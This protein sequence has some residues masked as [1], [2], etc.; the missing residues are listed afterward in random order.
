VTRFVL[1][2][3]VPARFGVRSIEAAALPV[4][5]LGRAG[6]WLRVLLALALLAAGGWLVWR[7][8]NA[9]DDKLDSLSPVP[10]ADQALDQRLR[11]D[12]G[13]PDVGELVVVSGGNA[14]AALEGAERV[15]AVL[16]RLQASGALA[17]FDSPARYLPSA[18]AQ[19]LRREALPDARNLQRNLTEATRTVPFR[20]DAFAPFIEQVEIARQ[21]PTLKREDLRG[22]G[23]ALKVDTLLVQRHG[24][25]FAMLPLRGVSQRDAIA[26]ALAAS[27][28][29]A[30]LLDLK[31][32]SDALYG[33]Y[34]SRALNFSLI[35]AAA[36]AI[37]LLV[38]LRSLR[39][40]L[41]VIVPLAAAIVATCAIL[42]A[43]GLQ[44]N[45][46]HLVALLLVV[47]VGSNYALFLEREALGAGDVRRTLAAVLLCN[48][49]TVIAFGL[50]AFSRSPVLSSIGVTV[51][52]G[53]FL[54]LVFAAVLAGPAERRLF[55]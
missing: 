33:G 7:G 43:A 55:G 32:E 16:E 44:L 37:L 39:R 13:A 28:P 42:I 4:L 35:G 29:N 8:G 19:R 26:A 6:R 50:L 5:A 21:R 31:R 48:V 20:V 18:N 2:A 34:R 47:G 9:W 40:T 36:I 25:W 22:T 12:L 3:L 52:L 11:A 27:D 38:G 15:G 54:T 46:F 49:S 10:A 30:V 14:D 1:P 51:A 23:F 17:G 45:L 24:T 53:T 41:R